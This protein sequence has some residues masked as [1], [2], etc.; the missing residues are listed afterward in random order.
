M[1]RPF[2]PAAIALAT[3]LP[4]I[5]AA[6][7]DIDATGS[8]RILSNDF[9]AL[10]LI[11]ERARSC[12][13][14]ELELSINQTEEHKNLQ[15]PALSIDPAEYTVALIANNS[16]PALLNRDLVRPLDDLV[17]RYGEQLSDAQLVRIGGDTVA[18]TFMVNGMHLFLRPDIL[19][20]A[21]IDE[22]PQSWDDVLDAAEAVRAAGLLDHPIVGAYAP[23][24][25]LA[26]EFV[27]MYSGTGAPFFEP[28]TA[29]PAIAGAEGIA[30]LEKMKALTEYMDPDYLAVDALE[31]ARV[32]GA[33]DAAIMNMWAS[34][35]GPL[36]DEGGDYPQVAANTELAPAPRMDGNEIPSGALFWDGFSIAANVPDEDAAASF[37]VMMHAIAP[38][39]AQENPTGA[40]WMIEGYAPA[41][42][43][44]GVMA[45]VDAGGVAY[46]TLP[47]MDLMHAALGDELADYLQGNETAE[48]ALAGVEAAYTAAARESGFLN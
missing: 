47:Y 14:E 40:S 28:G 21:G 31:A 48:E 10:D 23:G 17:A 36:I 8:V 2:G 20:E 32:W 13:S 46:P 9:A 7:C 26:Q 42:N 1:I 39:L 4:G 12:A 11:M 27:N 19:A 25:D 3:I 37:Q 34:Q 5:A 16:L 35:A 30:V 6:Q 33:G 15:V 45:N 24:W 41:P 43:A 18:V 22:T 29:E 44:V 38:E